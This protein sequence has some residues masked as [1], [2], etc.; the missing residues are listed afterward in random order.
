M[1]DDLK[2][3]RDREDPVQVYVILKNKLQDCI[4]KDFHLHNAINLAGR[5]RNALPD[6]YINAKHY[7][8][9]V[10]KVL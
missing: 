4:L 6:Q 8:D 5:L 10:K 7:I 9:E 1:N 3:F 2:M